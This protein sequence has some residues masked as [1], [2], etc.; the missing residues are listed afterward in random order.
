MW[1][2]L[3]SRY[4]QPRNYD[5]EKKSDEGSPKEDTSPIKKIIKLKGNV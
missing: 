2:S 3:N 4:G 1:K 5:P